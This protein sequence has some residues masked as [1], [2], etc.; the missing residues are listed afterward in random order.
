MNSRFYSIIAVLKINSLNSKFY[1]TIEIIISHYLN[2]PLINHQMTQSFVHW[3][4]LW[5]ALNCSHVIVDPNG[6]W[7][8]CKNH[9]IVENVNDPTTDA[10]DGLL[11][12]WENRKWV[13]NR[14][15]HQEAEE[16]EH[17]M[18]LLLSL[19]CDTWDLCHE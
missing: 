15:V 2:I 5:Q 11:R 1:N 4:L 14:C 9:F 10:L 17:K 7:V 8:L 18:V 3:D 13:F 16:G 12:S 6:K 19:V